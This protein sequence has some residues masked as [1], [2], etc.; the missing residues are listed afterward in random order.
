MANDPDNKPAVLIVEDDDQVAYLMQY[1]LEQDGWVV[2]RAAD[3][4]NARELIARLPP[5]ALVTLDIALPDTT[6]VELILNIKDTPG[7]ERVPIVMVTAKPKDKDV[8]WAIKTG[9]KAYIVKPF[10]PEALRDCVR[11]LARKPAAG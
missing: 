11:R 3:G 1:I 8:N 7:W 4:K 5:P 6:G 10:K 2:H 9:A